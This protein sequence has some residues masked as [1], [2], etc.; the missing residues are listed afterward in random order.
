MTRQI[1]LVNRRLA[2]LAIGL[3]GAGLL[4]GATAFAQQPAAADATRPLRIVVPFSAGTTVDAVGRA[5]ATRLS[6]AL[7]R[8]V[9]VD[10]KPG[11]AGALGSRD[12]AKSTA[13]R[14]TLLFTVSNT[15]TIN[16][17]IYANLGYQEQELQPVAMVGA[18]SYLL[19]ANPASGIKTIPD[20]IAKA[21]AAGTPLTYG[22]YGVGSGPHLCMELF[23][24]RSG[25]TLTHVPYKTPPIQDVVGGH[26]D[27]SVEPPV[28]ALPFADEGKVN[29]LGYTTTLK[30]GRSKNPI[31]SVSDALPG[32]E[33]SAWL[34][35]F[36][37]T[38]AG[39]EFATRIHAEVQ[40]Q[41][42]NPDVRTRIRDLGL[43]PATMPRAEFRTYVEKEV[44]HW[45]RVVKAAGI[46]PQ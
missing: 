13:P 1:E 22:S 25:I 31:P 20:L 39:P 2:A 14:D 15:I 23:T 34:A 18:G 40:R 27:L 21:K 45:G 8:P 11:V 29:A 32:Y 10:N 3:A 36:A 42:D 4:P 37:P 44:L 30:I 6:E 7:G 24:Q 26:L 16:P 46:K 35:F 28:T 38:A 41:L 9:I 12:V 17:H 43:E 33:C 19:V 5:L